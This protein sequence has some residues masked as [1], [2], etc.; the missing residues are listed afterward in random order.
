[1]SNLYKKK[2]SLHRE[3]CGKYSKSYVEPARGRSQ[4]QVFLTSV[5]RVTLP[6]SQ[7]HQKARRDGADTNIKEHVHY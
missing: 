5:P 6:P 2:K 7:T 4:I 1:M 3:N